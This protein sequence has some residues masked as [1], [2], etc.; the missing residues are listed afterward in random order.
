MSNNTTK[1]KNTNI[2]KIDKPFLKIIEE[3]EEDLRKI[4]LLK[5]KKDDIKILQE[6]D[7][8]KKEVKIDKPKEVK[9]DKL[10]ET[11]KPKKPKKVFDKTPYIHNTD[12]YNDFYKEELKKITDNKKRKLAK[13]WLD[14]ALA[15]R[16]YQFK[17]MIAQ[18]T[19]KYKPIEIV[20]DKGHTFLQSPDG[21]KNG[22]Q[23]CAFCSDKA[24][25]TLESFIQLAKS[26]PKHQKYPGKYS[27]HLIKEFPGMTEDVEIWCRTCGD[28]FTICANNHAN[29]GQGCKACL[30]NIKLTKDQFVKMAKEVHSDDDYDYVG[31]YKDTATEMIILHKTCGRLFSQRPGMHLQAHGCNLCY[32]KRAKPLE[33]LKKNMTEKYGDLFD[34]KDVTEF[35]ENNTTWFTVWCNTCG[36]SFETTI[37]MHVDQDAGC[38]HCK[39]GNFSGMSLKW[40][41]Y[42]Q[43]IDKANIQH[44]GNIG[45]YRI[46]GT[47]HKA[48]GYCKE[49]KTIYEFHGD[50]WHGNPK[51]KNPNALNEKNGR[52][53]GELYKET[54]EKERIIKSLGYNYISI[55]ESEWLLHRNLELIRKGTALHVCKL[56]GQAPYK[57]RNNYIKHMRIKHS[58]AITIYYDE[59]PDMENAVTIVYEEKID[60]INI[61][62]EKIIEVDIT[63]IDITNTN[64]T[65]ENISEVDIS[66]EKSNEE[67][68]KNEQPRK[69]IGKYEILEELAFAE[70]YNTERINNKKLEKVELLEELP[71]EIEVKINS[72][73]PK[74]LSST[75]MSH[76]DN[77]YE[78]KAT[79]E[80]IEIIDD[81]QK[82][83]SKITLID[84][85]QNK[86]LITKNPKAPR[87]TQK[88]N[89]RIVENIED[90]TENDIDI[91]KAIPNYKRNKKVFS[92]QKYK[93]TFC[94]KEYTKSGSLKNH[95]DKNHKGSSQHVEPI[96]QC[97][98][99]GKTFTRQ[100]T[101]RLHKN[102]PKIHP[103]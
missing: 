97:D 42:R 33:E 87:K 78:D 11:E 69:R 64:I 31:T 56:C 18:Y 45:E 50:Y 43:T 66:K 99:C 75:N 34:Y 21:H 62:E 67:K 74:V 60:D 92:E 68:N 7:P 32:T 90:E 6:I 41:E 1:P 14:K 19:N 49:T 80:Q 26:H 101:L 63:E 58:I 17:Y 88:L 89:K 96:I 5:N 83:S 9:I 94:P 2:K 82:D 57:M 3:H 71:E 93:C 72:N 29:G 51:I 86:Q 47:N 98:L 28:S 16:G 53:F 48:D 102:N 100:N 76:P 35:I 84:D 85:N 22:G 59:N 79:K 15:Y 44:A 70:D 65:K 40:L 52:L 103:K 39:E 23:G 95:V 10:K 20:C 25:H 30:A 12:I 81:S 55:W 91:I 46:P 36:K 37:K 4:D 38:K 77:D 27:Y 13:T 24:P 61:N 8:P 54:L 73:L